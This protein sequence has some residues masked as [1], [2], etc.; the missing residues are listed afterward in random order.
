MP[1]KIEAVY[2]VEKD[3]EALAIRAARY[4]ADQVTKAAQ[5]RPF[6]RVAISGGHTPKRMFE[7]LAAAPYRDEIPWNKVELFW[8]DE[9]MV[10][11]DH[12]DSNYR[13]TR[14]ALLDHVPI[15]PDRIIRIHGEGTP[16][17]AAIQYKLA[18]QKALQLEGFEQPAFDLVA[19][20]MGPDGH[21]ASLFPHT[22]A[23]QE[24]LMEIA[25]ANHV[26]S[27]KDAWRVT[28]TWPVIN[29]AQN[30]FFL[31]QGEDKAEVLHS[32]LLGPR[33]PEQYPSQLIWPR[34]G[35][36]TLLLDSAAASLLPKPGPDGQGRLEIVQ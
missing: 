16:A 15:R 8:V 21:T 1:K 3:P 12:P 32:V 5:V 10:P 18:I 14:E 25:V 34:S 30:V 13:M 27:Q 22:G 23:L 33:D 4:F 24:R 9:R 7:L 20:G 19:L 11:P 29:N 2:I 31:I 6:A 26:P 28:L 17:G 36:L 35:K